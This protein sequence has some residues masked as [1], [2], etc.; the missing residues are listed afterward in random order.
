MPPRRKVLSVVIATAT[1][2]ALA[3]VA[4]TLNG[5]E[6]TAGSH[7]IAS[8]NVPLTDVDS[9]AAT[10]DGLTVAWRTDWDTQL[11]VEAVVGATIVAHDGAILPTS[12][13][14]VTIAGQ[15]GN[16]LGTITSVNGGETWTAPPL[17]IPA[18]EAQ[19]ASVVINDGEM[20]DAVTAPR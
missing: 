4:A 16:T 13:I 11:G 20:I 14:N 15:T 18:N 12:T 3:A 7:D 6:L 1:F 19:T 10:A 9:T 2:V 8:V 5:V 17:P